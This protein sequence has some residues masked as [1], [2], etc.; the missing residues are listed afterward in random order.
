MAEALRIMA[1]DPGVHPIHRR[2]ARELVA[3]WDTER[4]LVYPRPSPVVV[5]LPESELRGEAD[6]RT[7]MDA[8]PTAQEPPP[9]APAS[10]LAAPGYRQGQRP[11][12]KRPSPEIRQR[13]E[14]ILL[15]LNQHGASQVKQICR[16]LDLTN[17]QVR[18][19]VDGEPF[20]RCGFSY[21]VS[22][23]AARVSTLWSAEHEARHGPPRVAGQEPDSLTGT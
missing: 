2:S 22:Y 5:R 13:I 17:M 9:A 18:Y 11:P 6:A 15:Y 16:A 21:D 4:R 1:D 3:E 23:A 8:R 7:A 19:L 14:L 12:L 10:P 20:V